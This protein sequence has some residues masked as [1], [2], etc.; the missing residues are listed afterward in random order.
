[1]TLLRRTT[2]KE[3]TVESSAE[4]RITQG[5]KHAGL[6]NVIAEAKTDVDHSR[7][8]ARK[9]VCSTW[10]HT[11]LVTDAGLDSEQTWIRCL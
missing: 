7:S 3:R 5:D 2:S 9:P 11:L 1:M 8:S 10:E 4:N 6:I